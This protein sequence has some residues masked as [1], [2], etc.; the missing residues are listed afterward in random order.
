[1]KEKIFNFKHLSLENYD[2]FVHC[3]TLKEQEDSNTTLPAMVNFAGFIICKCGYIEIQTDDTTFRVENGELLTLFPKLVLN[4]IYCS[5]DFDGI[6]IVVR[7]DYLREISIFST[8]TTL[9]SVLHIK[10]NPVIRLTSEQEETLTSMYEI[11]KSKFDRTKHHFKDEIIGF[12]LI[13]FFYEVFAIYMDGNHSKQT[14]HTRKEEL[15]KKFLM[16]LSEYSNRERTVEFYAKKLYI[17]P[18]YLSTLVTEVSGRS[19]LNWIAQ[20]V[21]SNAKTLLRNSDLSVQQISIELNFPNSSFF[22][23]YFKRVTG[24]TPKTYKKKF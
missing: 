8:H 11:I 6:G 23:Q 3:F 12:L 9:M 5:N 21:I 22:G 14:T 17:S 18:K 2:S 15:F 19:A 4:S 16:L 20:S 1:M 13:S 7:N 10:D 24:M